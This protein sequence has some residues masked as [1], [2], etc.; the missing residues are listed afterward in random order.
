M[1][2]AT[3]AVMVGNRDFF[4]DRLVTEGRNDLLALCR[5]LDIEPV[6]LEESDTKLGSVETWRHAKACAELFRRHAGRIEGILVSLPNFG[7]EKGVADTIRLS[8]LRVPVLV[9]AY[10]DQDRSS[11][12]WSAAAMPSAAR[13]RFATICINTASRFR[14]PYSTL[15]ARIPH[16]SVPICCASPRS[17]KW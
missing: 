10:P 16:P 3:I 15:F 7:D 11:S 17:A 4:P 6:M 13:S 2:K 1:P 8:G 14:S 12:P 5:E 9:Q